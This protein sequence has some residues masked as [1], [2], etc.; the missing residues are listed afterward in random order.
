[1]SRMTVHGGDICRQRRAR[2]AFGR[3][4]SLSDEVPTEPRG[5]G[6]EFEIPIDQIEL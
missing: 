1:M 4:W 6:V 3:A 2:P 5:D